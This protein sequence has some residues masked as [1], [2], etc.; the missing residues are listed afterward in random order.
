MRGK[1]NFEQPQRSL[2]GDR[3]RGL[4]PHREPFSGYSLEGLGPRFLGDLALRARVDPVRQQPA[5]LIALF[6][7][8]LER[9]VRVT[10]PSDSNFSDLP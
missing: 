10:L 9:H 3:H 7:R 6:P 1:S 4:R 5:R 8:T 2:L